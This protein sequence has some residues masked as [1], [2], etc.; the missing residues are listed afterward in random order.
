MKTFLLASCCPPLWAHSIGLWLLL[1]LS[2]LTASAQTF[3]KGADTG[4]LQQMEANNYYFYNDQGIR[5]DCFQI[6]KD[7]GINSIRLRVWV[8]PSMVDWVNGHCSPAE[9]VTMATRAKNMGF[10]LMIDFHYSDSWADPGQQNKPAAWAGHS[11][12]QLQADVYDHTASVL[13]ALK[14]NGVTPEWVQVGNEIPNGMLWP[15][16]RTTNFGQLTQLLN[17]GYDAVKAVSPTSKVV[18]H[19]DKGNDN[20]RFRSF[21]DQL[22]ANG[23]KYDVIGM[24]YYPFWLNQD[25]SVSISSL[26]YNLNDMASRYGKEVIVAEVG[27]D[28]VAAPQNVYDMLVAVQNAVYAVPN[29]KGLGVFYWEP[30]GY[31]SFSGYQLSAWSNDGKPT[32]AMNAF[33]VTPTAP[34][35]P[36]SGTNVLANPGFEA[37]NAATQTPTGWTSW[38]NTTANYAADKTE[39]GGQASTYRLTH[40]LGSAYQVSTYQVKTGLPNGSYTLRAWVQSSGGQTACQLYAKNFG[41]A[42]KNVNLPVTSTWA[43]VQI[44]GIQVTNGQCEIGLWSDA[45]ANNWCNFDNVE[46]FSTTVTAIRATAAPAA[47][48][49]YPNPATDRLTLSLPTGA[50]EATATVYS[51][52]GKLMLRQ[53]VQAAAATVDVSRLTAGF[54]QVRVEGKGYLEVQKF[55]KQ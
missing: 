11:F 26:Q 3:A 21:F 34:A 50:T 12:T 14:N 27:G 4:W 10:R 15:E 51:L 9:V 38:A 33:L 18:I 41:G 48:T 44:T 16:G 19:L 24:S 1:F 36:A 47:R 55:V 8:N 37:N 43:Q 23:G 53:S 45:N 52:T 17:K 42:E 32:A 46:L 20:A 28:A 39:A 40:W 7:K 22:T 30:E 13:T 31:R 49:P 6:L 25:Y 5:Q 35:P 54:Y 29:G 2:S